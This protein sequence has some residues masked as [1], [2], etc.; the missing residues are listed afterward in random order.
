MQPPAY[1]PK[2]HCLNHTP[3]ASFISFISL[4]ARLALTRSFAL[5]PDQNPAHAQDDGFKRRF[6]IPYFYTPATL[7]LYS[8]KASST[9]CLAVVSPGTLCDGWIKS[10]T[11]R[12]ANISATVVTV[13]HT[14]VTNAMVETGPTLSR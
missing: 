7:F 1:L 5:H 10:L 4:F 2:I 6:L 9:L 13:I 8:A 11:P 12:S 3:T 14:Q